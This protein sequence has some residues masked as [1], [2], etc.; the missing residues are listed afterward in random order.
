MILARRAARPQ[1]RTALRQGHAQLR[2]LPIIESHRLAKFARLRESA[3][4]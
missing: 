3:R 2:L 4:T 1:P